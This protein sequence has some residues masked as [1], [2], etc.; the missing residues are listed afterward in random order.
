MT[1]RAITGADVWRD[2][3]GLTEMVVSRGIDGRFHFTTNDL[4]RPG[5]DEGRTGFTA[6]FSGEVARTIAAFIEGD[7]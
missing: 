5:R 7:Q 6:S 2:Q 1:G 4:G 3:D